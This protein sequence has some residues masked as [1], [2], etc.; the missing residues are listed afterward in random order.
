MVQWR[1]EGH[2]VWL[3]MYRQEAMVQWICEGH[4]VWRD[5]YRKEAMVQWR[6][7]G[8]IVWLDMY[9][10]EAMVQWRCEGHLV[11]HKLSISAI[12]SFLLRT[13]TWKPYWCQDRWRRTQERNARLML[14]VLCY[15]HLKSLSSCCWRLVCTCGDYFLMTTSVLDLHLCWPVKWVITNLL[16]VP[17]GSILKHSILA[18]LWA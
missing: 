12:I 18:Q 7:E 1:C 9:R 15:H 2:L 4:L 6:C 10:Q 8:H 5:M 14:H 16:T 3:D 17:L 11:W 13:R